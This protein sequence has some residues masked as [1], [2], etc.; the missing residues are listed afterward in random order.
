MA[1]VGQGDIRDP[2]GVEW[3]SYDNEG[4]EDA[5]TNSENGNGSPHR[6]RRP[7]NTHKPKALVAPAPNLHVKCPIILAKSDEDAECHLLCSHDWMNSQGIV[8][9]EKCASFCVTLAGDAYFMI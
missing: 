9:E 5:L 3:I 8:E 2:L 7:R 1:D 4:D 6:S